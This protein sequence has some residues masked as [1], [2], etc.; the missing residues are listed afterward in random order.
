VRSVVPVDYFLLHVATSGDRKVVPALVRPPG[1]RRWE[2]V[3]V[4]RSAGLR[5]AHE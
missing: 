4:G 1:L 3:S 2:S 5:D